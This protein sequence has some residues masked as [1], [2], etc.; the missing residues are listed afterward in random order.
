MATKQPATLLYD[1][2]CRFCRAATGLLLAW[3]R[4]RRL[5]P[6]ALQDP[7]AG[8]RLEGLSEEQRMGSWHLVGAGGERSSAGRAFAPLFDLL[9]AGAPLAAL[10]R[11]FPSPT[12]AAYGFVSSRRNSLVKLVPPFAQRAAEGEIERRSGA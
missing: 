3:D 10:A 1:A 4:G 7:A 8:E 6:L 12:A 11:R 5:N 2:E 9:P